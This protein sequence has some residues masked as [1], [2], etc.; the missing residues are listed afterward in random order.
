MR[1]YFVVLEFLQ[2][3]KYIGMS[4]ILYVLIFSCSD[5]VKWCHD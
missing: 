5:E 3:R 1:L 2:L 4:Y